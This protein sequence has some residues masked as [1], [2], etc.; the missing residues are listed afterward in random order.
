MDF[1]LGASGSASTASDMESP[2]VE[3][4]VTP[5]IYQ[6]K[7]RFVN[8]KVNDRGDFLTHQQPHELTTQRRSDQPSN[9]PISWYVQGAHGQTSDGVTV[10]SAAMV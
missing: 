5:P 8:R 4:L 7:G 9:R 1:S 2:T 10:P 3:R 6:F